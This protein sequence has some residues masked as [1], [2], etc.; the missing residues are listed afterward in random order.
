MVRRKET[1]NVL[2]VGLDQSIA[3]V[4][5]DAFAGGDA[6]YLSGSNLERAV[7]AKVQPGYN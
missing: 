5:Q 4:E 7:V 3:N 1:E 2:L 6:P